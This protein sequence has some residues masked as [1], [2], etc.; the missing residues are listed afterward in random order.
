[1]RAFFTVLICSAAFALG[2]CDDGVQYYGR[3]QGEPYFD[4]CGQFTS[5]LQC[6]PMYGC[7]WCSY[8]QGQGFCFSEPNLCRTEQFSWTWET[9][10][11]P[12]GFDSGAATPVDEA[13]TGGEGSGQTDA[14][15]DR[16][17]GL[18]GRDAGDSETD[19]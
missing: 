2:G 12:G 1:M 13:G 15:A 4:Y 18:E 17:D 16:A 7:G 11:C 9:E 5:C 3:Y 10:G 6:T 14:A 19:R 8:G